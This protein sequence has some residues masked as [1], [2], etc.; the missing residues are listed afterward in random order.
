MRRRFRGGQGAGEGG[1]QAL[2]NLYRFAEAIVLLLLARMEQAHG[3]A[4]ASE[5]EGLAM[6]GSGLDGPVIYRTLRQL[7]AEGCVASGWDTSGSGPARR[8]YRLTAQGRKRLD[9]W[10]GVI[11]SVAGAMSDFAKQ[12]KALGAKR[13]RKS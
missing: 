6:T 1:P 7:E 2:G 9:E 13:P 12:Y 10:A 4:L 11:E 3:Y 5:A 8:V